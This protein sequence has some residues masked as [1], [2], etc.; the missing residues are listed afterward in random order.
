MLS[1]RRLE[2]T[3]GVVCPLLKS[4][5]VVV[6]AQRVLLPLKGLNP[7]KKRISALK[8]LNTSLKVFFC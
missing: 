4:S 2:E 3:A 7:R 6:E 1:A 5:G 8:M